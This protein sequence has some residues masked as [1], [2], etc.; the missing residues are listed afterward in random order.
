[1]RTEQ[2]LSLGDTGITVQEN[3]GCS[4]WQLKE[5]LNCGVGEDS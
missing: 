1:M 2:E 5:E 4:A 3:E